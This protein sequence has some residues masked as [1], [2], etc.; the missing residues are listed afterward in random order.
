MASVHALL[1]PAA[2]RWRLS[3][4]RWQR[5]APRVLVAQSGPLTVLQHQWVGLLHAGPGATL[6]RE[7]AAS[8]DGLRGYES[9]LVQVVV[10]SGR[11]VPRL[12][13]LVVHRS[14]ALTD[15]DVHP[16]RMPRRTRLPRS[17]V[18]AARYADSDDR[19]A[20]LLLAAVQQRLTHPEALHDVLERLPCAR[21]HRL[22]LEIVTDAAG[23]SHSL[24]E[25]QFLRLLR[26]SRLP[27]PERQAVRLDSQ[28]RRRYLD[29][30]WDR[31]STC[32]EIDGGAHVQVSAWWGYMERHND[33]LF[34]GKRLLRFPA[35]TIRQQP[36][37]VAA[38]IARAL[39]KGGWAGPCPFP[40]SGQQDK[41]QT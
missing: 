20:A 27:V 13:G 39:R 14:T 28:G 3:S 5:S 15:V 9:D 8:L 24:P 18:D 40:S 29:A 1:G 36:E 32:V 21:R 38:R 11:H 23:G 16:L 17:I 25:V 22:L 41:T 10:R 2:V 31:Y 6:G 33:E 12:R 37:R 19:A 35:Y 30:D 4:G 26:Q 34:D 7:T